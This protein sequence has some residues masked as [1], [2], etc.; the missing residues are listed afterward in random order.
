MLLENNL[1]KYL[2]FLLLSLSV[3]LIASCASAPKNEEEGGDFLTR[4]ETLAEEAQ[5]CL[6]SK[7]KTSGSC[8]RFAKSYK[9]GGLEA[10]EKFSANTTKYFEKDFDSALEK[11][12]EITVISEAI[13]LLVEP[14]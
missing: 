2:N 12:K 1:F 14:G 9:S 10:M 13:I 5:A 8:G 6:D 11:V 3:L 4:L 7:T